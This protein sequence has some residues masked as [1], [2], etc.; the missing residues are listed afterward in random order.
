M[1]ILS[2]VSPNDNSVITISQATAVQDKTGQHTKAMVVHHLP[3]H[4]EGTS[5]KE[6]TRASTARASERMKTRGSQ[7]IAEVGCFAIK[8]A[9]FMH[10]GDPGFRDEAT[11][12]DNANVD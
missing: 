11:F 6:H 7:Q 5:A 9:Y 3:D 4:L 10:L 1:L 12:G 8:Q 2:P